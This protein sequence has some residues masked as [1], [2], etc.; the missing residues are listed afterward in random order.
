MRKKKIALPDDLA[1]G[2]SSAELAAAGINMKGTESGRVSA[3]AENLSNR[4]KK[5]RLTRKQLAEKR[6]AQARAEEENG[7]AEV[8]APSATAQIATNLAKLIPDVPSVY[9]E[10]G[11]LVLVLGTRNG[12]V[13]FFSTREGGSSHDMRFPDFMR[14]MRQPKSPCNAYRLAL[15]ILARK[16]VGLLSIR[17]RDERKILAML[18]LSEEE[19]LKL[20]PKQFGAEYAR[21][22]GKPVPPDQP[23]TKSVKELL[24]SIESQVAK[25]EDP[26]TEEE[27][28]QVAKAAEKAA[29][30]KEGEA[31]P[32]QP[33][34]K[35][36]APMTTK[37]AKTKK[38]SAAK[39]DK[40]KKSGKP[41][42]ANGK[43]KTAGTKKPA[44]AAPKKKKSDHSDWPTPYRPGSMKEK[45]YQQFVKTGGDRA[46]TIEYTEKLGA[47]E[48]TAR[49]WFSRF[50]KVKK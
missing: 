18:K 13:H 8:I 41:A 30:K 44:S 27:K 17:V 43:K 2:I 49:S 33:T 38:S 37:K 40:S 50:C 19:L 36:D 39:P 32:D 11:Y 46:K 47:T 9:R 20:D 4:P 10:D 21:I 1:A 23:M 45:A 14:C 42:A 48:S 12:E 6:A 5:K 26:K 16:R 29:E 31:K 3:S 28:K 7:H 24:M 34:E 35:G 15:N 25:T 22:V